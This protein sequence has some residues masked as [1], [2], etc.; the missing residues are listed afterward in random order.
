MNRK[1][2][3]LVAAVIVFVVGGLLAGRYDLNGHVD[4]WITH[5]LGHEPQGG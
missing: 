3:A 4:T 5:V 1:R 2:A